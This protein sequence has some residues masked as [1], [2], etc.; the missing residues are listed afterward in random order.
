MWLE[1]ITAKD[2]E[3]LVEGQHFV[4]TQEMT[5]EK[6]QEITYRG[7]FGFDG[8]VLRSL[9]KADS[10]TISFSAVLLNEAVASLGKNAMNAEETLEGYR[11]FTITCTRGN[12]TVTYNGCNWERIT[13]RSTLTEV[14][15]DADIQVPGY[16]HT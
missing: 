2:L 1:A 15:L 14:T 16:G 7:G 8:P 6:R 10:G 11:D 13:I 5:E 4:A 3:I 12:R 9:R